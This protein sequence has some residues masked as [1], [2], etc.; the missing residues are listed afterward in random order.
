MVLGASL[1]RLA[2]GAQRGV[3]C[4][5][6]N[7]HTT[8]RRAAVPWNGKAFS[9]PAAPAFTFE[10]NCVLYG[11]LGTSAV[12]TFLMCFKPDGSPYRWAEKIA[13]E[14]LGPDPANAPVKKYEG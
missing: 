1:R 11:V 13:E 3:R 10:Q 14:E 9:D 2:K 7:L 5:K 8:R 12:V 4:T 6:Q